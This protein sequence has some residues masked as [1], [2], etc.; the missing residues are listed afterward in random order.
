[1]KYLFISVFL[2]F[3]TSTLFA[4]DQEIEI[5]EISDDTVLEKAPIPFAIIEKV[6]IYPGCTGKDNEVLRKCM[7]KNISAFV[8]E[9]FDSSGISKN[10]SA[11][12]HKISV[13]FTINKKGRITN[14]RTLDSSK[15]IEGKI[16]NM[17]KK[18]PKMIPGQQK[19]KNVGVAYAL[20]IV[21]LLN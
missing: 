2:L 8:A 3:S 13:F 17:L 15:E 19:G 7:S 9:N 12:K 6:P 21:F 10:L 1:M 4:Q 14:I 11:G 5:I 20:P 16:I 18:L